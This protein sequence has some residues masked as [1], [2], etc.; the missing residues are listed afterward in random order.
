M[1]TDDESPWTAK[2]NA[3]KWTKQTCRAC[4][5]A[6]HMPKGGVESVS[7][8]E[9]QFPC[10]LCKGRGVVRVVGTGGAALTEERVKAIVNEHMA[11]HIEYMHAGP[12]I[13]PRLTALERASA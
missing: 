3:A 6:G 11:A 8:G 9:A 12:R 4:G 2:A 7:G 5:G 10:W 13:L 1:T